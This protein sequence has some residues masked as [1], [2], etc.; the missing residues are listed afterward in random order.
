MAFAPDGGVAYVL[1]E[2]DS[3]LTSFAVAPATGALEA[4]QTLSTLPPGAAAAGNATAHVAVSPDGRW[5]FASNRGHNSIAVF[6]ASRDGG[7][8][9][10]L[11]PVGWET[12][13]GDV[14]VPRD[15]ALSPAG[16]LLV[17]ANKAADSVNVVR[18]DAATG[19]LSKLATTALPAGRA[20][21]CV[22]WV[23]R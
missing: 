2:L 7:D 17:V 16:D 3:T 8:S 12:G 1:N 6:A 21:T 14:C 15:F 23:A 13:G 22:A 9:A 19:A 18:V 20:P 11:T 4:P 5:V 10:R